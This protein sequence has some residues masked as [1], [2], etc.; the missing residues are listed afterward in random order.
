MR[1]H[2]TRSR[3]HRRKLAAASAVIGLGVFSAACSSGAGTSAA[4]E[5]SFTLTI[6]SAVPAATLASTK[7]VQ[8]DLVPTIK[9]RV[10]DETTYEVHFEE[11]FGTVVSIGEESTGIQTGQLDMGTIIFPY[12]PAAF[13][14]Q[15]TPYYVP[16]SSRDLRVT[17]P[18]YRAVHEAHG[19]LE[20]AL[21]E[22]NQIPLAFFGVGD[23]GLVTTDDWGSIRDLR[24][25]Q[26]AGVGANLN[27]LDGTGATPVQ[28]PAPEWYPS[29]QTGVFN[30]GVNY[31]DGVLNLRLNEVADYFTDL[32]FGSVPL[33]AISVN[34]DAWERLPAEVQEVIR[35]V[36]LEWEER[37]AA[38]VQE[39]IDGGLDQMR[40]GG[41][42]V[43]S[44]DDLRP[45]WARMLGHLP[46]ERARE[47][48]SMGL[49][50]TAVI[51]TYIQEQEK[52]GHQFPI[53]YDLG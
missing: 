7:A 2:S 32:Q 5:D 33:G 45:E 49:P 29:L 23:Y 18:A 24:G 17:L 38:S 12:E 43:N 15:N 34:S 21:A 39:V 41:M 22:R 26:L 19:E 9:S 13:P 44:G 35:T 53:S 31:I 16:F 51:Q 47:L 37:T 40:T 11:L 25:R 42:T 30:G 52:L 10:A 46:R 4:G 20:Q 3:S 48:D 50:G 14:L 1:I 27:W 28:A 36:A 6:G 8:D